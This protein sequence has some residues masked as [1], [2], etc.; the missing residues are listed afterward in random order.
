M[1]CLV[2][3]LNYEQKTE[4]INMVNV[5]STFAWEGRMN[6]IWTHTKI[7]KYCQTSKKARLFYLNCHP[8]SVKLVQISNCYAIACAPYNVLDPKIV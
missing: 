6:L 5:M 2:V 8:K 1:K 3:W 4:P 7:E